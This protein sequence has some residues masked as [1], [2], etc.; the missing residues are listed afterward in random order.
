MGVSRTWLQTV[1]C[2]LTVDRRSSGPGYLAA[3]AAFGRTGT[4][5]TARL[6]RISEH[7]F[8]RSAKEWTGAK[9]SVDRYGSERSWLRIADGCFGD[10]VS[11]TLA[12]TGRVR[13][14]WRRSRGRN[15]RTTTWPAGLSACRAGKSSAVRPH[16]KRCRPPR[17]TRYSTAQ[18]ACEN[19][20]L[21]FL[22]HAAKA[23]GALAAAGYHPLNCFRLAGAQPWIRQP[24]RATA[25]LDRRPRMQW[26]APGDREQGRPTS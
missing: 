8:R 11:I 23:S 6:L 15:V 1:N 26:A 19:T 13:N 14:I 20:P 10:I 16:G 2:C 4:L 9:A 5:N 12:Q 18:V 25:V 3:L 24:M 21:V 22:A 17:S 7:H